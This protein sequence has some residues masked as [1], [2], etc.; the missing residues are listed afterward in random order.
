MPRIAKGRDRVMTREDIAAE[1]LR[2]FDGGTS[3][4]S[5]R[6]VAAALGVTPSAIYYHFDSRAA[7][8]QAAV[9]MVW[10]E[11]LRDFFAVIPDPLAADPTEVLVTAGVVTRRTFDRH[12]RIAPFLAARPERSDLLVAVLDVLAGVFERLGVRAED[13]ATSFYAYASFTL[14]WVVFSASRRVANE[15]LGIEGNGNAESEPPRPADQ[16]SA[17]RDAIDGVVG[18]V[19]AER[20]EELFAAALRR[21]ILSFSVRLP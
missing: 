7:F 1:T 13:T 21:L 19:S 20:S 9:E 5:V 10:D 15:Q 16:P 18:A 3:A 6:S 11:A 14:G 8:V 4:P 17:T 2:Q 12:H